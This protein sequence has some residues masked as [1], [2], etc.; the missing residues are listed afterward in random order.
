MLS[1]LLAVLAPAAEPVGHF[2]PPVLATRSEAYSRASDVATERYQAASGRV[3]AMATALT[4]YETAL[5][6]LGDRAPEGG[7][8]HLEALR[9][10]YDRERARLQAFVQVFME[11]LDGEFYAAMQRA[12]PAGAEA[13]APTIQTG[14][15]LPGMPAPT[16]P[17]PDCQGPDLNDRVAAAM[18]EDPALN[19]AIEEILAIEWP[20]IT[21]PDEPRPA[22]GPEG[23]WVAVTPWFRTMI[24][25]PL[26]RIATE[27][28]RARVPFEAAIEEGASKEDL[29]AMASEARAVTAATAQKRART[30]A[31]LLEA[32][33]R[34]NEKRAKKGQ[35]TVAWCAQP[36]LLGGCT[37]EEVTES[38]GA[39]LRADKRVQKA[40]P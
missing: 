10:R 23:G 16:R 14:R 40:R 13:C 26:E 27:D 22:V 36:A 24:P 37:G 38:L 21:I 35:P 1:L 30:A 11:D 33:A 15:A 2:H 8:A 19:A 12:V 17:N 39:E 32:V 6:L 9:T 34:W 7:R 29:K 20:T 31:P 18:D 25:G 4:A 3:Q 5:D 28:A